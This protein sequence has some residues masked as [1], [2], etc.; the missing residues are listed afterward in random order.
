MPVNR[1]EYNQLGIGDCGHVVTTWP[2]RG[3]L[4]GN[5]ARVICDDCTRTEY[6]VLNGE[7][8]IWVRLKEKGVTPTLLADQ[9]KRKRTPR[10]KAV[11][12]PKPLGTLAALL[13][14]EGY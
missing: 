8:F 14:R 9:P 3:S 2:L 13:K 7:N 5:K 6:G 4:W 12:K 10:K 1:G 11:P